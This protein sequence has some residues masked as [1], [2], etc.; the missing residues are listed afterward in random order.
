MTAP[1]TTL[2]GAAFDPRPSRSTD[3]VKITLESAV[4]AG[5][6][7]VGVLVPAA[8]EPSLQVVVGRAGLA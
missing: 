1:T 7:A 8:G 5:V 6:D 3:A 4:P 2:P